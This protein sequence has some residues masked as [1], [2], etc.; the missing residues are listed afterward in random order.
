MSRYLWIDVIFSSLLHRIGGKSR[1]VFLFTLCN[2]NK[3]KIHNANITLFKQL[4]IWL[5]GFF[6]IIIIIPL[7]LKF[8]LTLSMFRHFL[9]FLF[10]IW[11]YSYINFYRLCAFSPKAWFIQIAIGLTITLSCDALPAFVTLNSNLLC[12]DSFFNL[13]ITFTSQS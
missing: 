6:S 4:F 5:C 1:H 7:D 8:W 11:S 3:V 2:I 9:S 10:K 12:L 13:T